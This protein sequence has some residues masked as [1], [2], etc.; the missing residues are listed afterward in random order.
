ML[1]EAKLDKQR[2]SKKNKLCRLVRLKMFGKNCDIIQ[3]LPALLL[4]DYYGEYESCEELRQ[5][6]ELT[7][8]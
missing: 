2:F 5:I 6:T 1:L 3:Q 7:L 8:R 4:L